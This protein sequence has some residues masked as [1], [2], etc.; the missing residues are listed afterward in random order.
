MPEQSAATRRTSSKP[1]DDLPE[2]TDEMLSR[3]VLMPS[4]KTRSISSKLS[5]GRWNSILFKLSSMLWWSKHLT[6]DGS[7]E[8]AG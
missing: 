8:C 7:G 2:L 4:A 3:A 5:S 6:Q 1:D